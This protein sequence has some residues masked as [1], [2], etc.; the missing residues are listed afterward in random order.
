MANTQF[1]PFKELL[2]KYDKN[3]TLNILEYNISAQMSSFFIN[4]SFAKWF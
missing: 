3:I 2:P 4:I 1:F